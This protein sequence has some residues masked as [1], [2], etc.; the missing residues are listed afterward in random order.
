MSKKTDDEQLRN[1]LLESPKGIAELLK[2]AAH[3]ARIQIL[4]LLLHGCHDFSELMQHTELS[5]T[6]LANHLNQLRKKGLVHRVARGEYGQGGHRVYTA[7]LLGNDS[8]PTISSVEPTVTV[9]P[10]PVVPVASGVDEDKVK[11]E[12]MKGLTTIGEIDTDTWTAF[13][14]SKGISTED[15]E[16]ITLEMVAE[17][18][19]IR[20]ATKIKKV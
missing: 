3:P 6:A 15:V 8:T 19:I 16:R 12:L 17:G 5:K 20:E 18:L 10:T 1:I 4:T 9:E 13:V 2:S 7:E 14:K 11:E